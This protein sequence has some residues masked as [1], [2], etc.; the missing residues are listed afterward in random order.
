MGDLSANSQF[1]MSI[2]PPSTDTLV[3][4]AGPE[5]FTTK[6]IDYL[7]KSGYVDDVIV[8]L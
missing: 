6:A 5:Y 1:R 8:A 2:P 4:V 7:I 3:L